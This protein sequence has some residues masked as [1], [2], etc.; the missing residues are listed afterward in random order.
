MVDAIFAIADALRYNDRVQRLVI[1]NVNVG[2]SGGSGSTI[3]NAAAGTG[4]GSGTSLRESF[5]A[6]GDALHFNKAIPLTHLDISYNTI[7]DKV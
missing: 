4:G 3:P 7:E 5:L 1:S 6:L 2:G